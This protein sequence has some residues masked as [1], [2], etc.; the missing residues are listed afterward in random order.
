MITKDK[1]NGVT[2][3]L[4]VT[5]KNEKG[6][7]KQEFDVP[8]QVVDDG[9]EYIAD[10]MKNGSGGTFN[11]RNEMKFMEIGHGNGDGTANTPGSGNTKLDGPKGGE[12]NTRK[13]CTVAVSA[14][15]ITYTATFLNG[16]STGFSTS[17]TPVAGTGE[18]TEAGIF[19]HQTDTFAQG[20]RMLCRTTFLPV[21]KETGD[22]MTI[23]WQVTIS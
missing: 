20:A 1:T 21:N 18:I 11:T 5:I 10:R 8:N 9:L 7:T 23:T 12:G 4:W 14:N 2:G 3:R 13:L 6:E 17:A 16:E 19:D 15:T 22:S